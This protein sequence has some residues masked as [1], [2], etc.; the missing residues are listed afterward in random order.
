MR[1]SANGLRVPVDPGLPAR[2][3]RLLGRPGACQL[4]G[5]KRLRR[6]ARPQAPARAEEVVDEEAVDPGSLPPPSI[7]LTLADEHGHWVN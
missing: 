3:A 7:D 5:P 6:P 2:V 4:L 1:A